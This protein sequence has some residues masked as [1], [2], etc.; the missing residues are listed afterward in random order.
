[1][2]LFEKCYDFSYGRSTR[3]QEYKAV[4]ETG[5]YPYFIPIE[6]S[7]DTEVIINGKKKVM[8]GSNNYLGLAHPPKVLFRCQSGGAS[9][10]G[11]SVHQ[12]YG[13]PYR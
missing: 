11:T 12:L 9:G 3:G 5:I 13:K 2:D 7:A 1:M 10:G 6:S 8:I 4:L